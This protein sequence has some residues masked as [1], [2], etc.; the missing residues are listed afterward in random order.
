MNFALKS[1]KPP[2]ESEGWTSLSRASRFIWEFV[3]KGKLFQSAI[4]NFLGAL[5]PGYINVAPLG[6]E[7]TI[8]H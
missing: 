2:E 3:V 8:N 7:G 6:L 5:P 4:E 1:K